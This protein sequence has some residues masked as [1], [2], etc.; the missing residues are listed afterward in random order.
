MVVAVPS[1]LV[2]EMTVNQVINVIA[3][4]NR[5]VAAAR[6]V[7]VV[8]LMTVAGVTGSAFCGVLGID[9]E[10]M[11]INMVSVEMVKVAIVEII[12]MVTV[13][14]SHVATVG[15]VLVIMRFVFF[16]IRHFDFLFLV[17]MKTNTVEH[18]FKCIVIQ[19]SN[20]VNPIYAP[21]CE[22]A[23]KPVLP[24]NGATRKPIIP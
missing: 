18:L 15:T 5:F 14:D 22:R 7:L 9:F 10:D 4:G 16:A 23:H 21:I 17:L 6:T 19:S 3:M 1:V 8:I 24:F 11:L 20:H 13:F 12:H 2:M